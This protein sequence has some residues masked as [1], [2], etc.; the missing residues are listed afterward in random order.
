MARAWA[1]AVDIGRLD[2]ARSARPSA[3]PAAR[4]A[5]NPRAHPGA[6]RSREGAAGRCQQRRLASSAGGRIHWCCGGEA[7]SPQPRRREGPGNRRSPWRAVL[8]PHW[9]QWQGQVDA[10]AR[11]RVAPSATFPELTVHYVLRGQHLGRRG[12]V[13]ASA[14]CSAD[15]SGGCCW[16]RR[17]SSRRRTRPRRAATP[18]PP[19]SSTPLTASSR[20]T[21]LCRRRAHAFTVWASRPS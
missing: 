19:S 8:R 20:S 9:A 12:R 11:P 17:P 21:R 18:S 10:A 4:Y 1:A 15:V 6:A 5:P 14:V 2:S 13:D 7:L 3:R 16:P